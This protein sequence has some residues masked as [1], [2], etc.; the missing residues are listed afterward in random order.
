[1]QFVPLFTIVSFVQIPEIGLAK[2]WDLVLIHFF[3]RPKS[4]H[5]TFKMK[6]E[7]I[8]KKICQKAR[9]MKKQYYGF[10]IERNFK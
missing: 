10:D 6:I 2:N 8:K 9:E 7:S 1:M 3:A 4:L 5:F